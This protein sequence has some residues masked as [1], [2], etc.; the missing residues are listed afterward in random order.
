[1]RVASVLAVL[2]VIGA[3]APA[4]EEELTPYSVPEI[5]QFLKVFKQTYNN[6]RQP[7]DDAIAVLADLQRAYRYVE[8]KGDAAEKDEEK[9]QK[10]IISYIERGL[11]ARKRPMVTLEC[12]RALGKIG[13]PSA[14]RSL[15][16]WMDKVVLDAKS[17][18]PNWVE[19]GFL[20]L[21]RIGGEDKQ[22][23]DLLIAYASGRH[24]DISVA[25][26]ALR[27]CYEWRSLS[28]KNRKELFEKVLNYLNS[29]WSNARGGDP[30][31]RGLYEKRY[32]TV[33]EEG[34][35]ALKEL[36]GAEKGYASP[37]KWLQWWKDNKRKRWED[38]EGVG[39]R[40]KETAAPP[41]KTEEQPPEE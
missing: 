24:V 7:E 14:A 16:R 41:D 26:P 19:T 34:L 15:L 17:V 1:M 2:L 40:K 33:S 23:L 22:T 9:A 10:K 32:K 27:A 8:S 12:A 25:P 37:E 3:K 28:G 5:E 13:D 20:S 30:K 11:K 4:E 31:K 35:K 36:S 38:Y 18:N 29:L 39:F 21:A 6:A